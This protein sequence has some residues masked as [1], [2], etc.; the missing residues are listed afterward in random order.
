MPKY[1]VTP[2]IAQAVIADTGVTV[3]LYNPPQSLSENDK[4][5]S[6]GTYDP[7]ADVETGEVPAVGA[8]LAFAI[9]GREESG[10]DHGRTVTYDYSVGVAPNGITVALQGAIRNVDSD[11]KTIDSMNVA[12][13]GRK[14]VNGVRANFLRLNVTAL[15]LGNGTLLVGRIM[16]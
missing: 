10:G 11:Y 14:T 5:Y 6:F 16:A 7:L 2:Y 15:D 1:I 4:G 13:G 8:G 9:P 12:T 3:P